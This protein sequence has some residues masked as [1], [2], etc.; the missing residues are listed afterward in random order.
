VLQPKIAV[1][2][3]VGR[4]AAKYG[5]TPRHVYEAAL[6]GFSADLTP[7]AVAGI[8]CEASVTYV[9]HNAVVRGVSGP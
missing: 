5:F 9:E 1:R 6:Q 2:A 8:R 4:L 7:T 3:E